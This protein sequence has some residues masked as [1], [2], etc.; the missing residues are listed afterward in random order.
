VRVERIGGITYGLHPVS[1]RQQNA[2]LAERTTAA[3]GEQNSYKSGNRE[4]R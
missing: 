3:T 1:A 2:R 4:G